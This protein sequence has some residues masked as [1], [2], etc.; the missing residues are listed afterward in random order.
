MSLGL[1]NNQFVWR[2]RFAPYDVATKQPTTIVLFPN[3]SQ[4]FFGDD[5]VEFDHFDT[6]AGSGCQSPLQTWSTRIYHDTYPTAI[7]S[8]CFYDGILRTVEEI[9]RESYVACIVYKDKRGD[10]Y[11]TQLCVTGS[12][13]TDET[14]KHA[15]VRELSEEVGV[16]CREES[17]KE[18]CNETFS[19]IN[20]FKKTVRTFILNAESV[21]PFSHDTNNPQQPCKGSDNRSNN[22]QVVVYGTYDRLLELF[23]NVYE[24]VNAEDTNKIIGVRI[25]S[26]WDWKNAMYKS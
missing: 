1:A 17:L 8:N 25:M 2:R 18:C 5:G 19:N 4:Q 21:V 22:I 23:G 12:V 20:H 13:K 14:F 9:P 11:D 15:C 24:R 10:I 16:S 7:I 6:V 3:G 26:H